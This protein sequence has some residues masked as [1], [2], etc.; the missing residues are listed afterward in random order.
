MNV[1]QRKPVAG[2]SITEEAT[3]SYDAMEISDK[4]PFSEG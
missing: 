2:P 4:C 1:F 3:S